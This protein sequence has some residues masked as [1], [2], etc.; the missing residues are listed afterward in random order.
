MST[1][2]L[3]DYLFFNLKKFGTYKVKCVQVRVH[4]GGGV[5]FMLLFNNF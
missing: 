5:H 3:S 4:T 2:D 1:T